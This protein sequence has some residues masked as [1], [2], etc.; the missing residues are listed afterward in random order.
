[1]GPV[2][3][4]CVFS[5][6]KYTKKTLS[7]ED[8]APF[9]VST[10]SAPSALRLQVVASFLLEHHSSC[11]PTLDKKVK[12][13][14]FPKVSNYCF[15][16]KGWIFF[17]CCLN[18]FLFLCFFL[19]CL[20]TGINWWIWDRKGLEYSSYLLYRCIF[21]LVIYKCKVIVRHPPEKP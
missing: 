14:L 11:Y 7:G 10:F 5:Y 12:R 19:C 9:W 21:R 6:T 8:L 20:F 16:C 1:M 13:H 15:K 17:F 3:P 4:L 18:C 2:K